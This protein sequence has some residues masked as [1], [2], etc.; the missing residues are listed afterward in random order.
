ML[1]LIWGDKSIIVRAFLLIFDES[2]RSCY[3]LLDVNRVQKQRKSIDSMHNSF[4]SHSTIWPPVWKLPMNKI[5]EPGWLLTSLVPATCISCIQRFGK[6]I[7][8]TLDRNLSSSASSQWT[9]F[10]SRRCSHDSHS[11][12]DR[13]S[14]IPLLQHGPRRQNGF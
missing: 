3:C 7:N 6:Q 11:L 1:P 10:E 4:K 12:T 2:F 9:S 8:R 5:Q 13:D 14:S